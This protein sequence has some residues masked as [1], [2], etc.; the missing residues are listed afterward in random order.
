MNNSKLTVL[1]PTTVYTLA[2]TLPLLLISILL[3]FA[4]SFLTLDRT[5]S[6]PPAEEYSA[7]PGSFDPKFKK[8]K[9]NLR[10]EGGVGGLA[11]GY[12]FGIHLST[13]LALLIPGTTSSASLSPKSFLAVWILSCIPTTV[14]GGLQRHVA[15]LF[16]GVGGGFS[17]AIGLSV[18]LHPSLLPR[19]IL[20]G[21]FSILL[22]TTIF[23][24]LYVSRFSLALRPALRTATSAMGSLGLVMSIA[25]LS[26]PQPVLGWANVWERLWVRNGDPAEWG[27]GNEKGLSAA[28]GVFWIFGIAGDWALSR[29]IGECPDEV[30]PTPLFLRM[31]DH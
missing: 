19:Q 22:T 16:A 23:A 14:L 26:R 4:G 9:L 18:I 29:W 12:A 15:L 25:L 13:L 1:V 21:I 8:R 11:I 30:S 6:F 28:W 2:Y 3:I 24:G 31:F 27:A 10:L 20:L 7:L 17:I 5:R